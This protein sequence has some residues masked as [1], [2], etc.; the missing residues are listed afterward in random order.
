MTLPHGLIVSCQAYQGDPLFGAPI[1]AAM[2]RAAQA[3]GAV[4]IRANGPE[5]IAAIRAAVPLPILGLWKI[6]ST[7]P[8]DVYITP[9]VASADAI[10]AAGADILAVDGTPRARRT[11]VMLRALIAH[12]H[13]RWRLPVMADISCLDD[14]LFAVDCGADVVGTTLAGYTAHGRPRGDDPDL[15]LLADVVHRL[16]H[17]PIVAEGRISTPEQA[18]AAFDCGAHAVVVGAA[19]TRP[20]Q[21]TARFVRASDARNRRGDPAAKED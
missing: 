3:G 8:L 10:A 21:I 14:A 17:V 16:P 7:G 4:A 15:A 5:D 13:E 19:I 1:M 18:A 11:G 12:I 2:A 9:D 20:E 6:G